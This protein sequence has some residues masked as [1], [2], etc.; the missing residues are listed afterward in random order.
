MRKLLKNSWLTFFGSFSALTDIQKKS[1]PLVMERKNALIIS[2]TASGKTE[3]VIAPLIE[4]ILYKDDVLNILYIVPTRA[5]TKDIYNRIYEQ[6]EQLRITIDIKTSDYPGLR[7]IPQILITTPESFDSLLCRKSKIFSDLEALVLDEIHLLDNTPRGDQLRFL[8][9]RLHQKIK[10]TFNIYAL[11]ATIPE[12][13]NLGKRYF[14]DFEIIISNQKRIIENTFCNSLE[15]IYNLAR[16]KELKKLLIFCNTRKKV[17]EIS[18]KAK[19]L[20]KNRF[21]VSHHGSLSK[22]VRTE[23]EEFMQTAS[24]GVCVATMTLEIGIDI[25][26]IDAVVLADIPFSISSFLQRIGRANRRSS[27]IKVISIVNN[28]Y[29]KS[30]IEDMIK[31]AKK[32]YFDTT[33]YK[34]SLGVVVQQIFSILFAAIYGKKMSFFIDFFREFCSE[35]TIRLILIKLVKLEWIEEKH[36]K[37]YASMKLMN[38]GRMGKIHSTIKDNGDSDVIDVM[39]KKKIGKI[40]FPFDKIF[41]LNGKLWEILHLKKNI[42]YVK[43]VMNKRFSSNFRFCPDKTAFDFLL[44]NE[45]REE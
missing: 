17:E 14:D 9:K 6:C 21:V 1:I 29:E 41:I 2:A 13:E 20:W 23:A 4:R 34:F 5:L 42:I 22:K 44:P 45:L 19:E 11:S 15:D 7:K 43:N 28:F 36:D 8:I 31:K 26:N 39:T 25:G 32:N 38:L 33:E 37:F 27:I 18:K 24:Y 30:M 10:G 3:A 40:S 35:E 16:K 12:P